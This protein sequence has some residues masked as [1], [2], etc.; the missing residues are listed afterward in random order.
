MTYLQRMK[1]ALRLSDERCFLESRMA[2]EQLQS[3]AL[4]MLNN[5]RNNWI[6]VCDPK[7]RQGPERSSTLY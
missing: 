2:I 1:T 5:L 4:Q 3:I 7:G 6:K